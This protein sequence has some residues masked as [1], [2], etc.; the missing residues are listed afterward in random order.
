MQFMKRPRHLPAQTTSAQLSHRPRNWPLSSNQRDAKAGQGRPWSKSAT[1]WGACSESRSPRFSSACASWSAGPLLQIQSA[2]RLRLRGRSPTISPTPSCRR[3]RTIARCGSI[4]R[5]S[6]GSRFIS[7]PNGEHSC[8]SPIPSRTRRSAGGTD[9]DRTRAGRIA[10]GAVRH[11]RGTLSTLHDL[12]WRLAAARA[13]TRAGSA[14][15]GCH[16]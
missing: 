3:W 5:A 9:R 4:C 7:R 8:T 12:G 15:G 1:A 6:L 10:T 13:R 2:A 11:D 16:P 14:T